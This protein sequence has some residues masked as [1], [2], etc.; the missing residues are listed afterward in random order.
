MKILFGVQGTGNGHVSRCR[1]LAK[2]LK[3]AGAD[4]VYIFSGRDPK[5]YF[6]MQVFGD[7]KTYR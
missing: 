1:T 3:K 6:D 4:V 7:Y 2:A 5:D